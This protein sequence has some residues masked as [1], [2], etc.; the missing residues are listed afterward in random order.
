V[1]ADEDIVL[2]AI[3][4]DASLPER[5][6]IFIPGGKVPNEYYKLTAQAIQNATTDVRLTV[7]IPEVFQ[8]LCIISCPFSKTCA[9][10][11]AR[12]DAAVAKSSFKSKDSKTDTFIAGHSL[13]ATCANNLVQGYNSEFAGLLEFGGFVNL[14]GSDSVANYSIPVLHMAGEVDGG[15]ARPSTLAGLYGQSKAYAQ[16]HTLEEALTLK[17]VHVLEG[18]DHSDFCPGFFVTATKDCKS[19]VT[20]ESALAT[21]GEVASAFLHLNSPTSDATK[22]AAMAAM[23]KRLAFTQD[24]CEPFL[25]AFELEGGQVESAPA[26]VPAGPWC[27]VGQRTIVGLKQ[28]DA[29]KLKVEP[30]KLITEGLHQFEH[31]H[32]NYTV[33]PDGSLDVTCFSAV[34]PPSFG[35]STSQFSA[36]SVDCKMV[37]ATRVAE[38]LHIDTNASVSC[39]DINRIAVEVAKKLVPQKSLKRFEEKGRPVCFMEDTTVPGN[40]GPLWISGS[41]VTQVETKDC[42]QVASPTLVSTIKSMIFPGNHYCK[43]LSPA[44]AMDWI[45]IDSHKPFPYPKDEVESHA[46][47]VV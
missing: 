11:K 40:I 46:P 13:G 25:T 5:L 7:V 17:P 32:T 24:M 3:Q 8:R 36:K 38:Q 29:T 21:I 41:K 33:L 39:A 47:I 16:S 45:M 9:P 28:S 30:C 19:E 10:L 15:G 4:S 20:Q 37:D 18:L 23:K 14:R 35:I 6:L 44:A 34:E 31:Q 22:A 27:E 43:L 12:L 26:G 1:T 42:L 2:P